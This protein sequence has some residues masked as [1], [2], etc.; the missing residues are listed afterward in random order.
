MT[1][2]AD[3]NAIECAVACTDLDGDG[4][5][6][7]GGTCGPIDCNDSDPAVNP[8]AEERCSDGIDNN[9][10]GLTDTADMNA[11]N[12]PLNCID[13]D[14]D[15]DGY[16]IEGGSCGAMNCN[17]DNDAVNPGALEICGDG[18]DNNCD[19]RADSAD[20]VCQDNT[21][22]DDDHDE[23]PWWRK[24]HKDRDHHHGSKGRDRNHRNDDDDDENESRRG[25]RDDKR[26]SHRRS[27]EHD[28]D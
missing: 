25:D 17:D 21:P 3:P 14:G 20:N 12:C 22:V 2:A 23:M 26:G 6:I 10:N 16:S 7:D 27:R 13:S 1:D 18:I 24:R 8:G 4:Y 28:D 19:N 11:V 5:N 9:C 15:G